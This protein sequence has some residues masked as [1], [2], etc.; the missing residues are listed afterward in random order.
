MQ[1][2][3][4]QEARDQGL[5]HYFT[6]KPCGRGH[7]A[8]RFVSIAKCTIC[9]REDTMKVYK[10]TT[11]KR[12]QYDDLDSFKA[13]AKKVHGDFYDYSKAVYENAHANVEIICPTHG[14]FFQAPTNHVQGKGCPKCANEQT[15]G[16]QTKSLETFVAQAKEVW[17][18]QFDYSA[19]VYGG[20]KTKLSFRCIKHDRELWQT[21]NNHITGAQNPCPQCNHMKSTGERQVFTFLSSL[22]NAES[23][24]KDI[25]GGKELD[26]YLPDQKIAVEYCGEFYHS[27][28]SKEQEAGMRKKHIEKYLSCKEVGIRLITLWESEWKQRNYAIR[29]LLR[30]AVGKSRGKL[31]ARKC[32]LRKA[33]NAEAKAFYERYHP[34]GGAGHG[35]HYALFWK[36]KMVACMRFVLGANDRGAAAG[37]R[38]WTLGRYATR[39]TVAGAA[40]RLFQAFIKEY[41]PSEVKSFSDNRMFD[42]KMYEKLGFIMEEEMPEDY[43]VYSPKIGIKPKPHYQRRQLCKRLQDHGIDEQFD[44][45][46]DPR[47][48]SEMTYYMGARRLFDCGKRRWV[49][50]QN[51]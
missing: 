25:L 40:S 19:T 6:G 23:R 34:Q 22:V 15:R 17:G 50:T 51:N 29:R 28:G 39:I 48:E 1:I 16:K 42:G 2:T 35:E 4:R 3:T 36:G 8:P 10:H 31:M 38:T 21:P 20:A 37:N 41:N 24:N 45:E 14:A 13:A 27:S 7:V 30:N 9:A 11:D 32:E 46:T 5:K 26:I 43:V 47:T 33:S 49:W 18:E 12:R 44:H